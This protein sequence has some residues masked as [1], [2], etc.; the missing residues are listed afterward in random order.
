M[1]ATY[2][3]GPGRGTVVAI[4]G[5]PSVKPPA[6]T[7]ACSPPPAPSA[8]LASRNLI[9]SHLQLRERRRNFNEAQMIE[10][11]VLL[12]TIGGDCPEDIYLLA[13][14]TCLERGLG[15]ELP[16]PTAVRGFLERFHDESLE[17]RHANNSSASSSPAA[18]RY[19]GC[20]RCWP[21]VCSAS[22]HSTNSMANGS[23]R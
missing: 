14:D 20:S 23:S 11:V 7:P 21:A 5:A 9:A 15:Y 8:P 18:P 17:A 12:Q 2:P 6:R 13:D 22:P 1:A 19:R 3:R 4:A 10:S 16:K